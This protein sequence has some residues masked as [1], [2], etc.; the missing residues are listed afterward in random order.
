MTPFPISLQ[1]SW[2]APTA[3]R[4]IVI[5]GGGDIVRD[6]HIPAYLKAQLPVAG[7]YDLDR[8]QA[9][10]RIDELGHGRVFD[11]MREAVDTPNAVFDVCTPPK[12]HLDVLQQL[13]CAAVVVMQKPMGR[14]FAE[15]RAIVDLCREKQFSAAVNFQLRFATHMLAVRDFVQ[16]GQLGELVDI[17]VHLN[18]DTPWDAF[19][20][21]REEP[22]VEILLHTVHYLDLIRLF[23]GDPVGVYARSVRHPRYAELTSTK[24]SIILNYGEQLRVCLSIN[25]VF[26]FGGSTQDAIFRFQGTHGAAVV[27]LGLM[28]DYPRGCPDSLEVVGKDTDGWQAV[29]LVGGWFPDGFIGTMHNLQRFAAGEDDALISPVGDAL[30]TMALV[31]ACYQSDAN[32]GVP[33][34][35]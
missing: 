20:F 19:P 18:V 7:V 15:S 6:A 21:L 2:P 24:S 28:L 33:L 1:Q 35:E 8:N 14:T 16:Q 3:P 23:V 17:D 5:L 27:R 26:P 4:P 12:A 34:P 13:P 30:R 32:G 9:E 31:D 29:P 22:R 25:H 10:Q 11:S